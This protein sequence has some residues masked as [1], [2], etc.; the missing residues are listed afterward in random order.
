M[1]VCTTVDNSRQAAAGP[2]DEAVLRAGCTTE[3]FEPRKADAVDPAQIRARDL[4]EGLLVWSH[5]QVARSRSPDHVIEVAHAARPGHRDGAA[6]GEIHGDTSSLIGVIERVHAAATIDRAGDLPARVD[7]ER[8]VAALPQQ[9]FHAAEGDR[10]ECSPKA[11]RGEPI[12]RPCIPAQ[13]HEGG[14]LDE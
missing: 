13:S 6:A 12:Q 3:I 7:H 4:P 10:G 8:V 9:A 1:A 14:S 2:H 5:Q 11:Q